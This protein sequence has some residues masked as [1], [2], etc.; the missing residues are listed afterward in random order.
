MDPAKILGIGVNYVDHRAKSGVRVTGVPAGFS[1][2]A[3]SQVG[4]GSPIL[5]PRNARMLDYE[6]E[7]AL[8]MSRDAS[9]VEED[10]SLLGAV[11]SLL[12]SRRQIRDSQWISGK[13]FTG[14]GAF[15]PRL[16]MLD[17]IEDLRCGWGPGS[18]V[19]SQA[20][21]PPT[22]GAA[23]WQRWRGG[24]PPSPPR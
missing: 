15:G 3:D 19:R 9:P 20:R 7:V 17:D 6:G 11:A 16:T 5:M 2:F 13:N 1:R 4:H 21:A 12:L 14:V 18:T 8:V 23:R 22:R 24:S 10:A